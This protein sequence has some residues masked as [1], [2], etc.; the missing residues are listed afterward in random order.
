MSGGFVK[1]RTWIGRYVKLI[2]NLS[3]AKLMAGNL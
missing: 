3:G 1:A 2:R